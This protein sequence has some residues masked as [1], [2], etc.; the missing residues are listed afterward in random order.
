MANVLVEESYLQNIAS[1]IR[2]KSGSNNTYTPA[3]M[4]TAISNIPQ[5]GTV[6]SSG[7]IIL[8]NFVN[9]E[10]YKSGQYVSGG[11]AN[12]GSKISY[13]TSSNNWRLYKG[14]IEA[15][16]KYLCSTYHTDYGDCKFII[17]DDDDVVLYKFTADRNYNINII[18]TTGY[19]DSN[20]LWL[21]VCIDKNC[22][23]ILS[24]NNTNIGDWLSSSNGQY[25]FAR[26]LIEIQ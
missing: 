1:A 13:S 3:Q 16:K 18:D 5:S 8:G 11:N 19:D 23:P 24:Q 25:I 9:L 7:S 12:V 4:A 15:D 26:E 10:L 14:Q 20:G 6:L 2:T 17:A 22:T 21:H